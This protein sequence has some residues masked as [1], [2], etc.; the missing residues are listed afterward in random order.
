ML[1]LANSVNYRVT[2]KGWDCKDDLKLLKYDDL[3]VKL[4]QYYHEYR[5]QDSTI[6]SE[7]SSIVG[8]PE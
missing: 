1:F 5:N 3:K 4:K 2:H 7:G 6:V 8:N